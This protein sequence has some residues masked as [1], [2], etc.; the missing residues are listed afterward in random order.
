MS[1]VCF[2]CNK[3][4]DLND[5]YKHKAMKDG[6][7][8]KCKICTSEDV[9]EHREFSERPRQYDK[10]RYQNNAAR[11]ERMMQRS[12]LWRKNNPIAYKAQTAVGN[13]LRDGKLTKKPCRFCGSKENLHAHHNDYVNFLNVVWLC[14][15]CHHRMHHDIPKTE[16]D[17]KTA[18]KT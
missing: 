16:G 2:K 6:H 13:A 1:K 17:N 3:E 4:K 8:N 11:R 14:A 18:G 15:R 5:F 9:R 12:K 10:E 7:L